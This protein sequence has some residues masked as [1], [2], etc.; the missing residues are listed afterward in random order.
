MYYITSYVIIIGK[1]VAS[2]GDDG[3]I[4]FWNNS[5]QNIH[6]LNDTDIAN[7]TI[8]SINFSHDSKL[9]AYSARNGFF[10]IYNI[11]QSEFV[12]NGKIPNDYVTSIQFNNDS[13]KVTISTSKGDVNS[14][15]SPTFQISNFK[16][17]LNTHITYM[18]Y[19]PFYADTIGLTTNNGSIKIISLINGEIMN[20]F[21]NFHSGTVTGLAFSPVAE[22]FLCTCGLDG[23][24]NFIDMKG[25]KLIK[26]LN[27]STQLTSVSFNLEGNHIICG[28]MN[29]NVLVYDLRNTD[30]PKFSLQ[31]NKNKINHIE[32]KKKM[33]LKHQTSKSLNDSNQ[34][35]DPS[36][37]LMNSGYSNSGHKINQSTYVIDSKQSPFKDMNTVVNNPISE[38]FTKSTKDYN[39]MNIIQNANKMIV[40]EQQ[41]EIKYVN[42]LNPTSVNYNNY[43]EL[44]VYNI[45][46]QTQ[47][48]VKNCIENETEKLKEF[49]H[50]NINSLHLELIRQFEFNQAEII[51][52]IKPIIIMNNKLNQEIEKLKR[53]NEDLKSKY[54]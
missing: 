48:F 42:G 45:D 54:F 51:Q 11:A 15:S 6:P 30:K 2:G 14:Y 9:L 17:Q 37:S 53:E 50:E 33:Q 40:E 23:K 29:G 47:E 43:N 24:L 28:D 27:T 46:P 44:E 16:M 4:K 21:T 36:K 1:I 3:I 12:L 5:L 34:L 49:V 25:N 19:S 26:T 41:P 7:S 18:K 13:T 8:T 20:N 22:V 39:K 38:L 35:T 31:G 52:N 32:V 10:K